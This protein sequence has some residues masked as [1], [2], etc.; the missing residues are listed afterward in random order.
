MDKKFI[1]KRFKGFIKFL[2]KLD[3]MG[4]SSLTEFLNNLTSKKLPK[5]NP[6][7]GQDL[8]KNWS[9]IQTEFDAICQNMREVL[10]K[11]RRQEIKILNL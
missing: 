3:K 4:T 10:L 9:L 6:F 2:N 5:I 7:N 1:G 11:M 8:K